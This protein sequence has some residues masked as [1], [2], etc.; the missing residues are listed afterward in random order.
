MPDFFDLEGLPLLVKVWGGLWLFILAGFLGLVPRILSLDNI[1]RQEAEGSVQSNLWR[2]NEHLYPKFALANGS[3]YV[4]SA[5]DIHELQNIVNECA[6]PMRRFSEC[7]RNAEL[8]KLAVGVLAGAFVLWVI[9]VMFTGLDERCT[10]IPLF[11]VPLGT[12]MFF[13]IKAAYHK[14]KI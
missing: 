3:D 13:A 1:L 10:G 5:N 2:V 12:A 14:A 7:R 6:A 8:A 4:N 9:L 11:V